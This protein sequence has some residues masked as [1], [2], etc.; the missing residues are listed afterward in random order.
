MAGSLSD[1][2]GFLFRRVGMTAWIFYR[3][4]GGLR[5]RD[6]AAGTVF[7]HAE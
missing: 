6:E 3:M 5:F 1:T 2:D 7:I 4:H